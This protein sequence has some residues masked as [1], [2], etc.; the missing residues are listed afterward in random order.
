MNILISWAITVSYILLIAS[1]ITMSAGKSVAQ[2]EPIDLSEYGTR[3]FGKP[4][5][6][7]GLKVGNWKDNQESGNP[8]ELGRKYILKFIQTS[9]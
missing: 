7:V 5:K 2:L 4:D 8:E 9:Y 3:L 1:K 6:D